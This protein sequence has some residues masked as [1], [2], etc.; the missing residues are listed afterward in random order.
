MADA[1]VHALRAQTSGKISGGGVTVSNPAQFAL[2]ALSFGVIDLFQPVIS[3][4]GSSVGLA[5]DRG[6]IKL[7]G[8]SAANLAGASFFARDGAKIF[9]SGTVLTAPAGAFHAQLGG[10]GG[11]IDLSSANLGADLPMRQNVQVN[12]QTPI[13]IVRRPFEVLTLANASGATFHGMVYDRVIFTGP[14]TDNRVFTINGTPVIGLKLRIERALNATGEDKVNINSLSTTILSLSLPGD[15]ADIEY[16]AAGWEIIGRGALG[17]LPTLEPISA[18]FSLAEQHGGR[19]LTPA[20]TNNAIVL[21]AAADYTFRD[22]YAVEIIPSVS[23]TLTVNTG[24]TVNG[25]S[26]GS[27]TLAAAPG[28]VRLI[29]KGSDSWALI[30]DATRD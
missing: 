7:N 25:L 30:G 12:R 29:R 26:A 20:D 23:T 4:C 15:W 14:I 1:G 24:V 27:W 17:P 22:N 6:E 19:I 18:S 9:A 2:N 5:G 10:G 11:E 21:R 28:S 13:G 16:T 8:G 3:G